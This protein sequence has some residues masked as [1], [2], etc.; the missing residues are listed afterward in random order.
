MT[1]FLVLLSGLIIC[2]FCYGIYVSQASLDIFPVEI[3]REHPPGYYDYRGAINVQTNLS[4]GLASPDKVIEEARL[5]GL[6]FL[7]LTD[8]NQFETA[9]PYNGYYGNLLV[10]SESEFSFLDSRVLYI[11]EQPGKRFDNSAEANLFLTDL[12][13]QSTTQSRD[14]IAILAHPFNQGR[15]SWTGAYP[16]GLHGLEILNSKSISSNV[17]RTSKLEVFWSLVIYPFNSKYSF[18]RLFREPAD[19][20]ALWDKLNQEHDVR[21]FSGADANAR[22]LPLANYLVH[23]PT[24]QKSLELT[25]NHILLS[26]ELTGH[27]QKDRQ[28]ILN[29]LRNGNL[30]FSLDLLGDPKG[31]NALL[32]DRDKTHLM[33]SKTVFR[34][35]MRI[36][37][38]LAQIPQAFYEIILWKDGE[39]IQLSNDPQLIHEVTEPG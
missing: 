16:P 25:S 5:A 38:K 28:K 37:A 39:K 31:F 34:K 23:F 7:I 11:G 4:L 12:L 9:E 8:V 27:F 24:Y 17:W 6:D 33:G 19:E 36:E 32:L 13:S 26:S 10:M 22:A 3:E 35:G 29:A 21:G 18:L 1:R 2:Y 20:T 15:A 14:G 30:Y